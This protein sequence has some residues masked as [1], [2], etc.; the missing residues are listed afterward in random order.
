TVRRATLGEVL[1]R[2]GRLAHA[3][4]GLGVGRGDRVGTLAWNQQEHLEAY[5]AVPCMGGVLHTLNLR[6]A[7][8][9]IAWI[10]ADAGDKVLLA[11]HTLGPIVERMRP[12]LPGDV[13][14]VTIPGAYE[15]LL[16]G[17]PGEPF[18]WPEMDE[19]EAAAMCFTSGTTGD[20]KGVVYSHRS[21][22]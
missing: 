19:S 13:R 21:M 14:I 18:P 9:Q 16:D 17:A 10:A 20:P 22:V 5:I 6:L 11:D 15:D 2:A 4:R 1:D 3:L 12:H 8:E 7:P